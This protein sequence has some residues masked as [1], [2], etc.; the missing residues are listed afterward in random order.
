MKKRITIAVGVV[1][2]GL[3]AWAGLVFFGK[4]P[5][6]EQGRCTMEAQ[7]CPDGS[8]V[9]RSGP[10]CT[11]APCPTVPIETP[12]ETPAAEDLVRVT[13]PLP[14][15]VIKSPLMIRG[16]ARGTWYFEASFPIAVVSEDGT[17]I[18]QGIAQAKGE[19]MTTEFVPFEA[20]IDFIAPP[21][22]IGSIVLSKDNPSGLPEN[23][24]HITIPIRF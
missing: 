3:A 17:V 9:G 15:S 7:L 16:E 2:I 24:A 6:E 8:A 10:L 21:T 18:G 5:S 19:W 4:Q 11:F 23:D 12:V 1:C 20:T 13:T 22:A 14:E